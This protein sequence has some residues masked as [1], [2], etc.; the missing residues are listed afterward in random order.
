[1]Y[2]CS[3][4]HFGSAG[5]RKQGAVTQNGWKRVLV[6]QKRGAVG[7]NRVLVVQEGLL[8]VETGGGGLKHMPY[9]EGLKEGAGGLKRVLGG[10]EGVLVG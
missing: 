8:G 7:Q 3:Y 4:V 9:G 2:D 5:A 10:S 1:M 6:V